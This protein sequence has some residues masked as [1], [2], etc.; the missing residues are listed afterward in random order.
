MVVTSCGSHSWPTH[1]LGVLR[2]ASPV[3]INTDTAHYQGRARQGDI[4]RGRRTA[5]RPEQSETRRPCTYCLEWPRRNSRM[6]CPAMPGT[7]SSVI[8]TVSSTASVKAAGYRI[9]SR[10]MYCNQLH[11]G[12]ISC[13]RLFSYIRCLSAAVVRGLCGPDHPH[14]WPSILSVSK[15]CII[16]KSIDPVVSC[17]F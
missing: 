10:I 9:V 8:G 4:C 3:V 17:Y 7:V 5:D 13:G 6:S 11:A 1:H 12:H 15:R 16:Y 14:W 2:R